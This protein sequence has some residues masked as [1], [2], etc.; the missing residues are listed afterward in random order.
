VIRAVA[1]ATAALLV[2]AALVPALPAAPPSAAAET[3]AITV[4]RQTP[5]V[6]TDDATL[7][8][9][10]VVT[11]GSEPLSDVRVQ[12]RASSRRIPNRSSLATAVAEQSIARAGT[13]VTGSAVRLVEALPAGGSAPFQLQ[14]PA[15][16]L[17]FG[18]A[19]AYVGAAE[20]RAT[21]ADGSRS[22][23]AFSQVLLPYWTPNAV[24]EPTPLA[25]LWPLLET[26][27]VDAEGVLLDDEVITAFAPGGRLARLLA[28]AGTAP[29][30]WY[31]D[32]DLLQTAALIADGARVRLADG[33]I[34]NRPPDPVVGAW[35]RQATTA[36]QQ[37][38]E[39]AALAPFADLDLTALV[40]AGRTPEVAA[41]FDA[42]ATAAAGLMEAPPAVNPVWPAGGADAAALRGVS[43]LGPTAV[44]LPSSQYPPDNDGIAT[45]SAV[46]RLPQRTGSLIG[47]LADD[48][49]AAA[50]AR[51][52]GSPAAALAGRQQILADT[53]L[54]ARER[55]SDARPQLLQPPRRWDPPAGSAADLLAALASA[56]W[57][58]LTSGADFAALPPDDIDRVALRYRGGPDELPPAIPA[59]A[60]PAE[61]AIAGLTQVLSDPTPVV[62]P[63]S[64]AVLRSASAAWRQA[65]PA[66]LA[67]A[68][69][70]AATGTRTAAGLRLAPRDEVTLTGRNGTIPLTVVNDLPSAATVVVTVSATPSVRLTLTDPG[71]VTV[72]PGRRLSVEV[73]AEAVASGTVQVTGRLLTTAGQAYGPEQSFRVQVRALGGIQ[74][75]IVIT[76]LIGLAVF[77]VV[78]IAL[79]ARSVTRAA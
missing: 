6:M 44:V 18:D 15:D 36:L 47:L 10:G 39:S 28:E 38:G 52:T 17:P 73:P 7:L 48:Q 76:G 65:Q 13:V 74:G 41:G 35:L 69:A 50:L 53:L 75:W 72:E 1:G 49:L 11:A 33:T 56:P 55:S 79:R 60:E 34:E 54:I 67:Y 19:G 66:G 42:A 45:G 30:T 23:V 24:A 58:T 61:T 59:A 20:V 57:L 37:A 29:V 78:R 68:T 14:I 64:Q 27:Q 25:V 32:A 8:L 26:P 16:D 77:T 63:L 46:V 40:R 5:A 21:D 31:A 70:T 9:T 2:G 22:R 4:N 12:F 3:P 51:G 71:T 62:T 43:E